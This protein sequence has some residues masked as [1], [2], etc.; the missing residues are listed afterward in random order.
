MKFSDGQTQAEL[1]I[2]FA[3]YVMKTVMQFRLEVDDV[4]GCRLSSDLFTTTNIVVSPPQEIKEG[5]GY[6]EFINSS[7]TVEPNQ[8][9][10]RIRLRRRGSYGRIKRAEIFTRDLT[11][12]VFTIKILLGKYRCWPNF[13]KSANK[14][15][16]P[17]VCTWLSWCLLI[18]SA[19]EGRDY[20]CNSNDMGTIVFGPAEI[21]KEIS[22]RIAKARAVSD[23]AF[24]LELR[25]NE[26]SASTLLIFAS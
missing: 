13:E 22:V 1:E 12:K 3:Q 10:A 17:F 8:Q 20:F 5:N 11:G 19:E 6:V 9:R 21:Y 18:G 24:K 15:T 25:N 26:E 4:R 7:Y 23:R 2:D 16:I 14:G